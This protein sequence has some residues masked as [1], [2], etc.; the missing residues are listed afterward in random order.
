M[1]KILFT[2]FVL[3]SNIFGFLRAKYTVQSEIHTIPI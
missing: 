3:K 1:P 2:V